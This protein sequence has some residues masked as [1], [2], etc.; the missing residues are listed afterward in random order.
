MLV[1]SANGPRNVANSLIAD[2]YIGERM[3]RYVSVVVIIA[4]SYEE[5]PGLVLIDALEQWQAKRTPPPRAA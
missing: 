2:I 4:G 1:H 3:G 5:V